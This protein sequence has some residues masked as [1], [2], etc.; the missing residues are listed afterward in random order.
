MMSYNKA[1][2]VRH[3]QASS[4]RGMWTYY[5]MHA[6]GS[7]EE[8]D[9]KKESEW[10]GMISQLGNGR[11]SFRAREEPCMHG[12]LVSKQEVGQTPNDRDDKDDGDFGCR[13]EA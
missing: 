6:C 2:A 8:E 7:D 5:T 4:Q 1:Y 9:R 11:R 3:F 13:H 12:D 10:N